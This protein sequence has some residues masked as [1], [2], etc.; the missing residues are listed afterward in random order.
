VSWGIIESRGCC[1]AEGLYVAAEKHTNRG[2][3]DEWEKV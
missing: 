1:G 2:V 3:R